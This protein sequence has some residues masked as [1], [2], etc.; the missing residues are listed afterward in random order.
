MIFLLPENNKEETYINDLVDN[1]IRE[2]YNSF[3]SIMYSIEYITKKLLYE[4]R[5]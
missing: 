1:S 5:Y 2:K 3:A 4:Y